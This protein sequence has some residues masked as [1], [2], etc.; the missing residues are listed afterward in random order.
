MDT[1]AKSR[2]SIWSQVCQPAVV[3][4]ALGYF[5]DIYDLVLFSIVRTSSLQSLGY[6]GRADHVS[7][8]RWQRCLRNPLGRRNRQSRLP[9]AG[10]LGLV[11]TGGD[12]RQR[13]GLQ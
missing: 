10:S 5:V 12:L 7:V 3:V 1:T 8:R 2:W 13:S 6:S 4:G 11:G 9:R